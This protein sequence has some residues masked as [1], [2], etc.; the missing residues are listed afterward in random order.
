MYGDVAD[1]PQAVRSRKIEDQREPPGGNGGFVVGIDGGRTVRHERAIAAHA[2]AFVIDEHS[3]VT[4]GMH[5]PGKM[6]RWMKSTERRAC[7]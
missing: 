5:E 3:A 7:S 4:E 2:V 6:W 1:R